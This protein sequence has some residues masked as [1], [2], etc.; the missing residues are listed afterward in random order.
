[1]NAHPTRWIVADDLSG[2]AEAAGV[3]VR[4]GRIATVLM[5]GGRAGEGATVVDLHVRNAGD[6]AEA[7]IR[8]GLGS[9]RRVDYVKI[10]SQLRGPVTALISVVSTT[11]AVVLSPALPLLDRSVRDGVPLLGGV[12][13]VDALHSAWRT[14]ATRA[15]RTLTDVTPTW[16]R[17]RRSSVSDVRSG[18]FASRL[19]NTRAGDVHI[20]DTADADD[21]DA[22][23]TA[24]RGAARRVTP[25]GS[26]GLLEALVRTSSSE[27]PTSPPSPGASDRVLLVL[28]TLEPVAMRQLDAIREGTT[29]LTVHRED[30]AET[31]AS[32]I[33]IALTGD[34]RVVVLTASN[35]TG[36]HDPSV[37]RRLGEAAG[38]AVRTQPRVALALIGGETA[39]QTL[40]AL[41][42]RSLSVA[43]EVHPGA[44]LCLTAEGRAVVTRPGSFGTD[45]SLSSIT[46]TLLGDLPRPTL[47]QGS[48]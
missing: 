22:V 44:V 14:E 11:S 37:A 48:P 6:R 43:G 33:R 13:L 42:E 9:R 15:P 39:R 19:Q 40:D 16:C 23:A 35:A 17:V 36:P 20:P 12:P 5:D 25:V 38:R 41:G 46:A 4:N 26:A 30:D 34:A 47:R 21:L 7:A 3:L 45:E 18:V 32:R 1:M 27:A 2:A 10:D 29:L 24:I 8:A 31:I 28:G